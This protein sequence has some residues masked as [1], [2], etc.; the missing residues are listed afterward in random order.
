MAETTTQVTGQ[1]T[2]RSGGESVAVTVHGAS[3][4]LDLLVPREA[5]V[6]D[7][8][9]EYATYCHLDSVPVLLTRTGRSLSPS[10]SLGSA[11]V[12]TGAVLVATFDPTPAAAPRE[13]HTPSRGE[14]GS[15]VGASLWLLL[16]GALVVLAAVVGARAG[17]A[18]LHLATVDLVFASALLAV[19]PFGRF[20]DERAVCA[21][22]FFAAG[23]YVVVWQ[24]GATQL[25]ITVGIAGLAAAVGAAVARALGSGP[26]AV[27]NVWIIAG[28]AVFVVPSLALLFSAPPQVT[29]AIL[30][31]F[32][33]LAARSVPGM[34]V[35]VPDQMLIDLE[36]LAITAWSARDRPRGRR[37][38]MLIAP[39]MMAELLA[40]GGHI[41][42]ASA[43]AVFVVVAIAVPALL[44]TAVYDLDRQGAKFL[45]FFVGAAL[46]L[47][48]RS[49]RHA[50]ARAF[51]RCAGI[52]AWAWL[53]G[54]LL[55]GASEGA[56]LYATTGAL[57]LAA[58]ITVAAV[59]TGRGW[60]SVWWARRAEIA[61]TLVGA[62]GVGSVVVASSLFR[63]VWELKS[64]G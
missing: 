39:D 30:L 26:R 32:A 17:S 34:A 15:G 55:T 13:R 22:V 47:A 19:L 11:G 36:K 20:V 14:G 62:F 58:V 12:D 61:E 10:S 8:A 49:Y 6:A 31:M 35:D 28:L 16:A 3:G 41:V 9:R 44:R 23:A 2:A 56:A 54:A 38:R 18:A 43:A 60:R 42:N 37:G 57:L 51:L 59:A 5:S 63:Q 46:L 21:P 25:P 53:A 7:V 1:A 52:V 24:P 40:R 48:G 29:W 33:M 50:P 27:Q 45:I 4:A 64:G